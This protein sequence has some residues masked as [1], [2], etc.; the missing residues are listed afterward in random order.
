MEQTKKY[1]PIALIACLVLLLVTKGAKAQDAFFSQYYAA[2]LYLNPAMAGKETN[3]TF[4]SNYRSQWNSVTAPY[5]T[6]QISVISPFHKGKFNKKQR[7]GIGATMFNDRAGT[8][9]LQTLG[10]SVTGA[11]NIESR[12]LMHLIS[13][14]GQAGFIQK[15]LDFSQLQWGSQYNPAAGNFD[16]TLTANEPDI[17]NQ[18]FMPDFSAGAMYFYNPSNNWLRSSS[19]AYLGMAVYHLTQ[20]NESMFQD[21]VRPLPRLVKLHGG[22]S[23]HMND[24]VNLAPSVLFMR[25]A[26]N[27]Q[28]NTGGYLEYRLFRGP[29][30]PAGFLTD[31]DVILG[32]WYR[33]QDSFIFTMGLSNKNLTLGF[34]YDLNA[35]SLRRNIS[36][37]T[38][39]AYEFSI[40]IRNSKDDRRRKFDTPRI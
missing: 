21:E 35:S 29:Y 4:N 8:G 17:N 34:S 2:S 33:L 27:N 23:F 5:T 40:Q 28:L 9:M 19:S 10:F 16:P 39:G 32:T 30:G 7:G 22:M 6:T 25:Q 38:P 14:G 3:F 15:S 11:Y 1:I 26:D 12:S 18:V 20:P 36:G 13:L 31:T 37:A 24:R